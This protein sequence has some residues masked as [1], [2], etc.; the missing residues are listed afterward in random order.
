MSA[1]DLSGPIQCLASSPGSTAVTALAAIYFG[2]ACYLATRT[3][4]GVGVARRKINE[5]N[6]QALY[7]A[8]GEASMLVEP[9]RLPFSPAL[10]FAVVDGNVP[11][12]FTNAFQEH[13]V[14]LAWIDTAESFRP[15]TGF[16]VGYG[17]ATALLAHE[18]Q[19]FV[20]VAGDVINGN[21]PALWW[22]EDPR[23]EVWRMVAGST[24][25]D[26]TQ[27]MITHLI[28]WH[29]QLY[30][31]VANAE[32]GLQLWRTE[33]TSEGVSADWHCVLRDGAGR[34]TGNREALALTVWQDQLYLATGRTGQTADNA[35]P[36]GV[37]LLRVDPEDHWEILAGGVRFTPEGIKAPLASVG[38]GFG[39]P[40]QVNLLGQFNHG[41]ALYI[42]TSALPE[43][44][45][46]VRQQLW[47][48][49]DGEQF[50]SLE[51]PAS[52]VEAAQ[53]LLALVY[54]GDS[55]LV[56]AGVLPDSVESDGAQSSVADSVAVAS[57]TETLPP[58]LTLWRW[59]L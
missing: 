30:V 40:A 53:P 14:A 31:A 4:A 59:L 39:D 42:A 36:L 5:S 28:A 37:E 22:S 13:G 9:A 55:V 45:E 43:V 26:S 29:G 54:L 50:D 32:R 19:L 41:D 11:R 1:S 34:Y 20:A 8:D 17:P 51:W 58:G 35:R 3:P 23:G 44:G 48:S 52:W 25:G 56:G 27:A 10:V 16:P 33:L 57:D 49:H 15:A 6:W 2:D 18:S 24:F 47:V 12:L 7:P 21:A 38:P 46:P